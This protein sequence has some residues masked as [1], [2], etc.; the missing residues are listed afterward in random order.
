M[1][2]S[3]PAASRARSLWENFDF[4]L[5]FTN[6]CSTDETLARILELREISLVR[7]SR[8]RAISVTKPL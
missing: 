7:S 8:Y 4:E 5:I 2:R 6:N 1:R 3:L